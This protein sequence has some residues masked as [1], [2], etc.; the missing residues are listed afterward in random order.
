MFIRCLCSVQSHTSCFQC[1]CLFFTDSSSPSLKS[2][3][4]QLP[5]SSCTATTT[6]ISTCGPTPPSQ[7]DAPP[8]VP[9]PTVPDPPELNR[10]EVAAADDDAPQAE[11]SK[12]EEVKKD[13]AESEVSRSSIEVSQCFVHKFNI[14]V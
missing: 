11:D 2:K 8:H 1:F 12:A 3:S 9:S 6:E 7:T 5:S 10:V 14:W 4:K 13:T